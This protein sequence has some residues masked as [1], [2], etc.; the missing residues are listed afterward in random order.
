[1][2]RAVVFVPGV[3]VAAA[4][5]VRRSPKVAAITIALRSGPSKAA[6]PRSP[7]TLVAPAER[8][9]ARHAQLCPSGSHRT[10]LAAFA[11]LLPSRLAHTCISPV[12]CS[13]WGADRWAGS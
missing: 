1:M 6:L 12:S 5:V 10:E 3:V 8:P 2:Q 4:L 13:L 9:S 7:H 11:L